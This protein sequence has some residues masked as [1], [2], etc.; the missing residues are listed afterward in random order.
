LSWY[1]DEEFASTDSVFDAHL[2]GSYVVVVNDEDNC[3]GRDSVHVDVL[4]AALLP[5]FLMA[6]S[7]PLGDTLLIVEVTQPKPKSIDWEIGGS[8]RIVE[9]GEYFAK[10]IFDEEGVFP[11]TLSSYADEG[12]MG[13]ERKS[14]LVTS[15]SPQNEQGENVYQQQN[16]ISLEVSPNPS[17]GEFN[18]LVK[19]HEAAPV[20]F[21]LV[22][23]DTGQIYETRKRQGLAEYNELFTHNGVGQFVV[24]VESAGERLMQKIIVF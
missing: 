14:I 3:I 7:V 10:V 9:R 20:T 19:M 15:A 11:V 5:S 12:C 18:A 22:R 1:H 24:F 13:Q 4:G 6:T 23:I 8:H 21:Y 17:Q 16:L 2:P